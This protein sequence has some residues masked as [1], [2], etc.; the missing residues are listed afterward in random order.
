MGVEPEHVETVDVRLVG[1][2]ITGK[3]TKSAWRKQLMFIFDAI[4]VIIN[5]SS[6]SDLGLVSLSWWKPSYFL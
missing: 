2:K 6:F 1:E 3:T 5:Q 4:F